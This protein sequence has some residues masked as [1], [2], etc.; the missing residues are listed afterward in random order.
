MRASEARADLTTLRERVLYALLGVCFA[1]A[2]SGCQRRVATVAPPPLIGTLTGRVRLADG[3]P[4]PAYAPADVARPPM[5]ERA[6]PPPPSECAA[7]NVEA[8]MPVKLTAERML[9]G[10]VVGASDFTHSHERK[11][12][13][14]KIAIEHCRLQPALV[15][16]RGSDILELENRDA[17]PFQPLFGPTL[18]ARSIAPGEKIRVSL[19]PGSVEPVQCSRAAP[20]G[21]TDVVTFYHP[22]FAKTDEHGDFRIDRFPAS[23]SVRVSAWHPL[24]EEAATYVWLEPGEHVAVELTLMP[25]PRFIAPPRP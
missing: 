3:M 8:R 5:Q 6:L 21:R 19:R 24:F 2:A 9:A 14:H 13:L 17:Y 1:A 20:C 7:A 25:K 10:V 15:V 22:V 16:A 23:E 18:R 11:P 12:Q 4:L